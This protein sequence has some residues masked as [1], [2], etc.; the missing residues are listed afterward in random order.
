M[1][2][3]SARVRVTGAMKL[4]SISS[5]TSSMLVS[6]AA[7]RWL[8][9]ALLINASTCPKAALAAPHGVWQ[10]CE[11]REV[12]RHRG[13]P[14]AA[15]L[16]HQ[17]IQLVFAA[18]ADHD[19]CATREERR[20]QRLANA[21]RGPRHPRHAI[22]ELHAGHDSSVRAGYAR[23][24]AMPRRRRTEPLETP[25]QDALP[26]RSA[27]RSWCGWCSRPTRHTTCTETC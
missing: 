11:L 18:R 22:T 24:I 14:L 8:R 15:V 13:H 25:P 10:V 1:A 26:S 20:H 21:R 17:R 5:R 2:G 23:R 12:H 16:R 19:L 27:L 6:S 9:P 7:E 4:R 3:A